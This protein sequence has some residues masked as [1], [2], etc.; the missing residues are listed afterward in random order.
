MSGTT[1]ID[2]TPFRIKPSLAKAQFAA[3]GQEVVIVVLQVVSCVQICLLL[4][5]VFVFQAQLPKIKIV[6]L[7]IFVYTK[8]YNIHAYTKPSI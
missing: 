3:L 5:L 7:C 1:A 8:I 4:S 6:C 2:L